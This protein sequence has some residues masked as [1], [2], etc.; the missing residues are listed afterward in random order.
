M[1]WL[2]RE[3][4]FYDVAFAPHMRPFSDGMSLFVWEVHM[5]PARFASNIDCGILQH[6][7]C[8]MSRPMHGNDGV[9]VPLDDISHNFHPH[10]LSLGSTPADPPYPLQNTDPHYEMVLY[11]VMLAYGRRSAA[12]LRSQKRWQPL[13]PLLMDHVPSFRYYYLL[14]LSCLSCSSCTPVWFGSCSAA[15]TQF[16]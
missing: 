8:L 9:A 11:C 15:I 6:A 10:N 3:R 2:G 16:L 13:L 12:F 4:A 7:S 5:L 14:C 1:I